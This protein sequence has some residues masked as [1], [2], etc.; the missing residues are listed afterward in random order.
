MD[1]TVEIE[2]SAGEQLAYMG[3]DG[4]VWAAELCRIMGVESGAVVPSAEEFKGMMLTWFA[5]A[6][7][8]GR[9]AGYSS[10]KA[11]LDN[12]IEEIQAHIPES[13]EASEGSA[14]SIV[15]DWISDLTGDDVCLVLRARG[16]GKKFVYMIE[17]RVT[18]ENLEDASYVHGMHP[19]PDPGPFGR[20][21]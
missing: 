16:V 17:H 8:A 21:R 4:A 5:N 10:G 13:Y 6:I 11:E 7:E 12:L 20:P 15:M 9:S 18:E 14:E 1:P 3:T 2:R 19:A